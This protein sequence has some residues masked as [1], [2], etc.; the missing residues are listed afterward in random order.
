MKN[1]KEDD[2]DDDDDVF[3]SA[4]LQTH[5]QID[6]ADV[7]VADIGP[8]APQC[9][10]SYGAFQ[11]PCLSMTGYDWCHPPSLNLNNNH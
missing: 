10:C 7:I 11:D 2:D 9:G 8:T 5:L 6:H 3:T 4:Y 1:Q